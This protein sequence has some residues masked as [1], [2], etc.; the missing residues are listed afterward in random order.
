MEEYFHN[1][2][3][4][5]Q[6]LLENISKDRELIH[7]LIKITQICCASIEKG[8]KIIFAGNGGSAADA[9]HFATELMIRFEKERKSIASIALNSDSSL[10]TACANDFG[11][12]E[13][14]KRQLEGLA[15]KNDVFI[16]ISTSGKSQNIVKAL[17]FSKKNKILS[18]LFTGANQSNVE[19]YCDYVIK[20]PSKNTARIQEGHTLI[21][22]ILCGIIEKNLQIK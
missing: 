4:E 6:T 9:Q 14:F 10:I 8:G 15:K 3:I 1:K 7:S 19:K 16:A 20:I 5:S 21:G 12:D 13:I 11:Y 18:V 2:I 22:H 17:E